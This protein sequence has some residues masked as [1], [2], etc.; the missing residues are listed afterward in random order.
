MHFAEWFPPSFRAIGAR[1]EHEEVVQPL[2]GAG[3][4]PKELPIIDQVW[5]KETD[6]A[7]PPRHNPEPQITQRKN[8]SRRRSILSLIP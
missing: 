4:A 2:L 7:T 3:G 6:A 8:P 1:E 5:R